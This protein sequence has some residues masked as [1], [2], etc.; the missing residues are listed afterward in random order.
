M[1][2]IIEENLFVMLV[3]SHSHRV[4]FGHIELHLPIIF[5]GP[6]LMLSGRSSIKI[7]NRIGPKTDPWGTPDNTGTGSEA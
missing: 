6:K 7:R 4:T 2:G 1:K 3:P 5:P